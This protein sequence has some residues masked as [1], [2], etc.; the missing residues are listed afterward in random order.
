PDLHTS[1]TMVSRMLLLDRLNWNVV[2]HA[3]LNLAFVLATTAL[4][5]GWHTWRRER[6]LEQVVERV[7]APVLAVVTGLLVVAAILLGAQSV[8]FIYFQF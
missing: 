4:A 7:P 3:P 6:S 2:Q 5:V 1:L 8:E